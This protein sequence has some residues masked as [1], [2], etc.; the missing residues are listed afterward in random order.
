MYS[1]LYSKQWK[2]SPNRFTACPDARHQWSI[3]VIPDFIY[4]SE[5]RLHSYFPIQSRIALTGQKKK[6]SVPCNPRIVSQR[7]HLCTTAPPRP[8]LSQVLPQIERERRE[9]SCRSGY[10]KRMGPLNCSFEIHGKAWGMPLLLQNY[11][12]SYCSV[13]RAAA[14]LYC[15]QPRPSLPYSQWVEIFENIAF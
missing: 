15:Q 8:S 4:H 11:Q 1:V 5:H 7:L 6:K 10:R 12:A 13:S 3:S 2:Q 14:L 9:P